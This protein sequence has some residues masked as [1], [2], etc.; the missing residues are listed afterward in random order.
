[1]CTCFRTPYLNGPANVVLEAE[2]HQ[3]DVEN[4]IEVDYQV[5]GLGPRHFVVSEPQND[6][7]LKDVETKNVKDY[8]D[9]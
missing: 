8:E 2:D 9:S 7:S 5:T 1:M 4:E 3:T 6:E